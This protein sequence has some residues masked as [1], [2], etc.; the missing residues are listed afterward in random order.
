MKPVLEESQEKPNEQANGKQGQ[1]TPAGNEAARI[2][3]LENQLAQA[4]QEATDNW[5]KYLRERAEMDNFRKR[6]ERLAGERVAY[7]KKALLRKII[8]VSD[9]VERGL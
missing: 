9:N 6:Q 4:R 1:A 7:E 8:E 5:N 2:A 3:E